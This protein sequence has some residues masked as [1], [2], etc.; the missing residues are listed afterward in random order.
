[1]VT[2]AA[3]HIS[4]GANE[5]LILAV[6]SLNTTFPPPNYHNNPQIMW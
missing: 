3:D 1:M 2:A 4:L 6:Q 5:L